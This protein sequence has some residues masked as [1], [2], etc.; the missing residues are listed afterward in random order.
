ML[1]PAHKYINAC[2]CPAGGAILVGKLRSTDG[3]SPL[4]HQVVMKV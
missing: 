1:L 4:K 2:D 3:S